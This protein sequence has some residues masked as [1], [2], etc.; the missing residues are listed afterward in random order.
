MELHP[1]GIDL[2]ETVFHL[3]DRT[4]FQRKR[5]SSQAVFP[6]PVTEVHSESVCPNKRDGRL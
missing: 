5:R 6:Q 3:V 1:I 4:R 2:G